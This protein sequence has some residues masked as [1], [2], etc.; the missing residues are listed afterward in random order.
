MALPLPGFHFKV[1]WGG[2]NIGFSE[3]SGLTMEIQPIEY[4]DGASSDFNTIKMPGLPKTANVVLGAVF[5]TPGI[6]VDTHVH[7]LSRR[8]GLSDHKDPVKV[9]FE[10]MEIIPKESWNDL[11][12]QL[13]YFGREICD[14][15]KP[16][17]QICPLYEVCLTKGK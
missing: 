6:V 7:R 12:L 13:I 5:N 4:R 1:E 3:A 10:L 17:C 15:K 14:A 8:L 9:E 11:S 2:T 16:L